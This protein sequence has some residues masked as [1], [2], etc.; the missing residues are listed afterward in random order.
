MGIAML[1]RRPMLD[2]GWAGCRLLVASLKNA[3]G[4]K[5][6]AG[7]LFQKWHPE[8]HSPAVILNDRRE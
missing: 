3:A 2:A 4:W 5:A 7:W 1:D 8:G 6:D